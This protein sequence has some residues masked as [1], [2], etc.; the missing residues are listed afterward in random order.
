MP[1]ITVGYHSR[2]ATK[3]KA[4]GEFFKPGQTI[5]PT[6]FELAMFPNKFKQVQEVEMDYEVPDEDE[7][8]DYSGLDN[9]K[10]IAAEY[11]ANPEG[12]D[13]EGILK[14]MD[15]VKKVPQKKANVEKLEKAI[16]KLL[17]ELED[18]KGA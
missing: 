9:V 12:Y 16:T 10:A 7:T 1:Y 13:E 11:I 6:K 4:E 17:E 8:I 14:L 5:E 2:P 18:G 3:N 15:L